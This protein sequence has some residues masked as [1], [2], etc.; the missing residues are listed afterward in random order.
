MQIRLIQVKRT[1]K[2]S[3]LWQESNER[4]LADADEAVQDRW[5]N[6]QGGRSAKAGVVG[7]DAGRT[8]QREFGIA[9]AVRAVRYCAA[10]IEMS[11]FRRDDK[12]RR[13]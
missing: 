4:G 1:N 9:L 6:V 10:M 11:F 8:R 3:Q 5:L 2:F 7:G 13:L 12:Y